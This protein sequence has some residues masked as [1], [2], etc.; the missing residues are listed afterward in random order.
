MFKNR[1]LNFHCCTSIHIFRINKPADFSNYDS[2]NA[3]VIPSTNAFNFSFT[4]LVW[5][6]NISVSISIA[7]NDRV[8]PQMG[9]LL[10]CLPTTAAE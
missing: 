10:L 5:L 3:F 7:C 1:N 9:Y 8:L 6:E 4:L 2:Y